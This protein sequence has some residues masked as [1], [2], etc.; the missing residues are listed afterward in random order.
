[1]DRKDNDRSAINCWQR[2]FRWRESPEKADFRLAG[3]LIS[4]TNAANKEIREL[5]AAAENLTG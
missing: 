2:E 4:V 1:V 5:R 3:G